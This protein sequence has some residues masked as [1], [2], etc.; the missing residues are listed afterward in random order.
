MAIDPVVV[1]IHELRATQQALVAARVE[2][3]DENAVDQ[4]ARMAALEGRIEGVRDR[5]LY[6]VPDGP[7]GASELIQIAANMLEASHG[8]YA[9]QL[10]RV[11]ARLGAGRRVP[12]D[13][14]W[15]RQMANAVTDGLCGTQTDAE[16][17]L[18]LAVKGATAPLIVYRAVD[19]PPKVVNDPI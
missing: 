15:L 10:R 6:T 7:V 19:M 13:I 12:S 1:L 9:D 8:P 11:A 3:R 2:I 16:R 17:L 14:L 18:H 4:A 5:L